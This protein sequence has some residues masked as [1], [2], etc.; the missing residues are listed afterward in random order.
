MPR[1]VING[2]VAYSTGMNSPADFQPPQS[3]LLMAM[4]D[5]VLHQ[6][7]S[8]LAQKKAEQEANPGVHVQIELSRDLIAQVRESFHLNILDGERR[9]H[10]L[11]HLLSS[12]LLEGEFELHSNVIGVLPGN[13]S[14]PFHIRERIERDALFSVTDI[15]L[16]N[17]MLDNF[18][19]HKDGLWVPLELSANFVEYIPKSRPTTNVNRLTSRVK[20]EEELWNKVTDEI[21]ALDQLVTRDKHL[22]QYSKFV[23]D[24]FGIKIVCEDDKTCT[25]VHERLRCIEMGPNLDAR[26]TELVGIDQFERTRSSNGKLLQFLETKDYLTCDASNMKKTGWRA[27]KSVVKW[28]D[29]LFEIQVQPL[30]NYYL[31]LDHMSGQSHGSFKLRRDALRDELSQR[32]PLYGFYRDLLRMLFLESTIS[33]DCQN[34]NVV[35][36]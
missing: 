31:E 24:I 13:D 4:H 22:R 10:V 8:Y 33:F 15:D 36:K 5:P 16:G 1:L 35:I 17:H 7:I 19:Y 26:N 28:H 27:L 6:F 12:I 25:E 2:G 9:L 30:S 18:R 23:K 32:I 20:A 14:R 29:R 34:A 21:F 3:P 11:A